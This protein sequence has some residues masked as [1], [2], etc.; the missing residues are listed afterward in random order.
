VKQ[1]PPRPWGLPR[2]DRACHHGLAVVAT[3]CGGS[4]SFR[5][6]RFGLLV[7]RLSFLGYFGPLLASIF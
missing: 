3:G 4:V 1:A 7:L 5:V 2:L 6:P